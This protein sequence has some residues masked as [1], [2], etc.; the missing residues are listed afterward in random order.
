[1]KLSLAPLAALSALIATAALAG[2]SVNTDDSGETTEDIKHQRTVMLVSDIDDTIKRTD[3]KNPAAAAFNAF[4]A[5]DQFDGMSALYTDWHGQTDT[6][7]K[8]I[9]LS[10]SPGPLIELGKHFLDESKFPG[11]TS[12]VKASVVSGRS[13]TESAGEFKT[14]K[15]LEM[16]DA[17]VAQKSVP[18]TYILIGDNG[19]QD[20]IAYGNFIDYVASKGGKTDHIYS[21]IHHVYDSPQGSEIQAP[22]RAW[23]TAG[24]LAV[25]L[26]ELKLVNDATVGSVL[27]EVSKGLSSDTD[28]VIPGFMSCSQFDNWPTLTGDVGTEDFATIESSVKN[29]C[30]Q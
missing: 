17:Q 30:S 2:C 28:D 9:Y 14:K 21:F 11:D 20:M 5:H 8:I 24:D 18:D 10:A 15:L 23:V 16:Y 3:I 19:E 29:L 27:S 26:H 6:K 1:M 4:Q 13:L 25:Q 7:K 22:H 12:D